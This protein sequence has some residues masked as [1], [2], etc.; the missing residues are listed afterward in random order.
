MYFD[1]AGEQI[2][3]KK[4]PKADIVCITH[5]HYDHFDI[6]AVDALR[7]DDTEIVCDRTTAESF[8]HACI[9]ML[10]GGHAEP[11]DGIRIDAVPA[12]N[13]TDGHTNFHPQARQDCGYIVTVGGT[14]IYVAGDT[15]DNADVLAIRDIDVA[16]LPV[17]QPYTMTVDQAVRVVEQIRPSIF[18]PY[19]YGGTDIRT[20]VDDL[21]R[22]LTAVT[23][24]RIRPLE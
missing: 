18:Y 1:P 11:M 5:H 24:V 7:K 4:L 16:F 13:I 2:D 8:E 23:E 20:D 14:R 3:W 12:Y 19:H 17:N 15:E 22:R 9:T 10:P 6:Q 21:S